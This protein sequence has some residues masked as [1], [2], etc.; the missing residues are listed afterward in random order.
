[1]SKNTNDLLR[2]FIWSLKNHYIQNGK[3][4][5]IRILIDIIWIIVLLAPL[6]LSFI[7]WGTNT[8]VT[9]AFYIF[10]ILF[11]NPKE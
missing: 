6:Y 11:L 1:M 3:L 4:D 2:R 9:I 7:H 10:Y 8:I 5:K